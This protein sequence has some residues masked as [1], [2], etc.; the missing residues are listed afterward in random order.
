MAVYSYPQSKE[1]N[2]VDIGAMLTDIESTISTRIFKLFCSKPYFYVVS[3]E[4]LT[5]EENNDLD[6]IVPPYLVWGEKWAILDINRLL[7]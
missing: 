1:N 3:D 2:S 4:D 6:S 7:I 5:T